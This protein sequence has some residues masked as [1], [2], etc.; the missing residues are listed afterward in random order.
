M[1]TRHAD[2]TAAVDSHRDLIAEELNVKQV[3]VETD[4]GKLVELAAKPNFRELGPRF[5][6]R[7]KEIAAA[8]GDLDHASVDRLVDGETVTVLGEE[9]TADDVVVQ[10]SPR[11]GVVVAADTEFSVAIDTTIDDDLMSEGFAR[12]IVNRIQSMRREAGLDVSDR[13]DVTWSSDEDLVADAF[14]AHADLIA[15]EVLAT[16]VTRED[17][18]N[19]SVVEVEGHALGLKIT[20]A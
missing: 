15:R 3:L 16:S 1:V 2:V 8:I 17:N 19:T 12:E 5:G 20:P 14:T 6:A 18:D 10:R 7:M 11:P 9:L 13:I 4:E